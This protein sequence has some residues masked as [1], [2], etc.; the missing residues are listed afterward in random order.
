MP[1]GENNLVIVL[2]DNVGNRSAEITSSFTIDSLKPIGSIVI[3]N[4]EETTYSSFVDLNFTVDG[5]GTSVVEM[6]L[7]N[8]GAFDSE[9]WEPYSETK[10]NWELAPYSGIRMVYVKFKDGNTKKVS[11]CKNKDETVNFLVLPSAIHFL[12][13]Q[14]VDKNVAVPRLAA[15]RNLNSFLKSPR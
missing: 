8:D 1:E 10:I 13:D 6:M 7:S 2:Y 15:G 12:S 4:G 3:N 9:I 5:T 11:Y 14:K